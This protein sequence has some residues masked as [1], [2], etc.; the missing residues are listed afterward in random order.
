M[1]LHHVEHREVKIQILIQHRQ[2]TTIQ[3]KTRTNLINRILAE[4]LR[5]QQ[6]IHNTQHSMS[7]RSKADVLSFM[8]SQIS[9]NQAGGQLVGGESIKV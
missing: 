9:Q 1:F 4:K 2:K 5:K 8:F 7:M 6:G 3:Q